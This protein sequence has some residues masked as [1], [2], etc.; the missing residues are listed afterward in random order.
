MRTLTLAFFFSI[1]FLV[2]SFPYSFTFTA[3]TSI[4]SSLPSP[5]KNYPTPLRLLVSASGRIKCQMDQTPSFDLVF[6]TWEITKLG[7]FCL[8][9]KIC[10][11]FLNLLLVGIKW[12]SI[13]YLFMILLYF[14]LKEVTKLWLFLFHNL[15]FWIC[16]GLELNKLQFFWWSIKIRPYWEQILVPPLTTITKNCSC[17][18]MR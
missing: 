7:F 12:T 9:I 14:G 16:W 15:K 18:G 8:I 17:G 2:C 3:T 6:Q 13:F 10:R 5:T 11:F 4:S 1:F